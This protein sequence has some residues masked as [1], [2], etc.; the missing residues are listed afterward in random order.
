MESTLIFI[1]ILA[2]AAAAETTTTTINDYKDREY[3]RM[4]ISWWPYN[5][6]ET[7]HCKWN[8][9]TCDDG[10]RVAAMNIQGCNRTDRTWRRR[11]DYLDVV[12]FPYL[13]RIHL[14]RTCGLDGEIPFQIGYLF[15][16]TYLN[17]SGNH[18]S[19]ELPS[20]L[21]AFTKLQVLD[22]S[23]N[24]ISG[25]IPIQIGNFSSLIFLDLS[26]NSISGQ[27][28][29]QLGY[30]VNAEIISVNLSGN[31][32][33][34]EIPVSLSNLKAVDLSN[35]DLDGLIPP[36]V[37]NKFPNSS[38]FGNS[39]LIAPSNSTIL[40]PEK[41]ARN[42]IAPSNPTILIPEK[43]ARNKN[44]RKIVIPITIALCWIFGGFIV[45][46]WCSKRKKSRRVTPVPKHGDIFKIWNYDGNIAYE[47]VIQSTAD[48]DLRYCIGTGGYGSVYRAVLPSGRV[49]AVKKL[50]RFEGEN[51]TYDMCF[52]NEAKILSEIRH[53]S[54]VKLSGF[55]L[56]NRCM[57]LIYD[58]MER[59]SLFT[60]LMDAD[61]AMD[62]DWVKRVNVV[63][64]I[65]DALSY[66]HHDCSPPILHR[67]ISSSNI[68]LNS[69]LEACVSDF[70]TARLLDPDS[71]NRTLLVG[72]RGYIA[73]ELAYTMVVTEKCDV[74]SFGV[75]ALEIMFGNHP[76]DFLSSMVSKKL[77]QSMMLQD[78]WDKR[79]PS[80]NDVK[81]QTYYEEEE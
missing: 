71:S 31:N 81:I 33:T 54:I 43:K 20:S 61:E 80:P 36:T 9:I 45:Y 35:N 12:A 53:R 58:Y 49:V 73:P 55:C 18:L 2:I 3:E 68:L 17:L 30:L 79:P 46:C 39:K 69:K 65:A 7:D 14:S 57:F 6:S 67:D 23:N 16:L 48:F 1:G 70:G 44:I 42:K 74:Y 75:V 10:G 25:A 72:T 11:L 63:K 47:D 8:G 4:A 51:P 5:N 27:I 19:H 62:L 32:V 78:L 77:D 41:K 52:R 40:I 21:P 59:G 24:N 22:V 50:H 64:A 56:H 60:V 66:M 13:N 37:W 76:G 34:G 15:R 28:P 26:R 38:F 29:V